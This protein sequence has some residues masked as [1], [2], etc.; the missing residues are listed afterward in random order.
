MRAAIRRAIHLTRL[1]IRTA[2]PASSACSTRRTV[3]TS[4]ARLASQSV[5]ARRLVRRPNHTPPYPIT[6]LRFVL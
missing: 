6:C 3:L 4:A 5:Q 2:N 1:M